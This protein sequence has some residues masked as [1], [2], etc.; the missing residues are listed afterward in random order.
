MFKATGMQMCVSRLMMPAVHGGTYSGA[1]KSD[2]DICIAGDGMVH[3]IQG[4]HKSAWY[5]LFHPSI[6]PSS[7]H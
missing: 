1:H 5:C 3:S 6:H 7:I 4:H 2:Q